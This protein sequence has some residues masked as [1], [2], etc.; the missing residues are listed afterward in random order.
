MS[1]GGLGG[2][3][4]TALGV[5][6][7]PETGGLSMMIP[8]IAGAAGGYLGGRLT[9]DKNP[10]MD[11][12]MGGVGGGLTGYSGLASG[13]GNVGHI[14][15]TIASHVPTM[16]GGTMG[17]GD[18]AAGTQA[19]TSAGALPWLSGAGNAAS[20]ALTPGTESFLQGLGGDNAVSQAVADVDPS[21]ANSA[22]SGIGSYLK[23]KDPLSLA[24]AGTTGLSAIQALLPHQ[25]VNVQQN[26][27]NVLNGT[28]FDGQLPKYTM[29]NTA[30][31]YNGDWYTY[32]QTPQT[33]MYNAQPVLQQAEGGL[34]KGYAQGGQVKGYAAGG[35]PMGAPPLMSPQAAPAPQIPVNPLTLKAAHHVGMVIGQHLKKAMPKTPLGQVHGKGGGHDDAVPAKLSQDEYVLSADIPQ[36]LG[37]G[38]SNEGAKILDK[39]VHNIRKHKTSKGGSFPPKAKNPLSY[40]PK[41]AKA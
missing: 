20:S 13:I 26:R 30:T 16:L 4:G 7:A 6:L 25:K 5:A 31:P 36:A 23:S 28:G 40:L 8:A 2:A 29:Q 15:D 24:L 12:L 32:G 3:A 37:D 41:K 9:G 19:V 38:S 17:L 33:P 21:L 1:G 34:V 39:F 22:S 35:M 18:I 27:A 10:L 14:G 11:A